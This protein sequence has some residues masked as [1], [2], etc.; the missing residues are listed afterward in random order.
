M[1]RKENNNIFFN[2]SIAKISIILLL[3]STTINSISTITRIPR[4]TIARFKTTSYSSSVDSNSI[5]SVDNRS[6]YISSTISDFVDSE[7][8][9]SFTSDPLQITMTSKSSNTQSSSTNPIDSNS[10]SDS[11]DTTDYSTVLPTRWRPRNR[12]GGASAATKQL[13]ISTSLLA[14][15]VILISA[16]LVLF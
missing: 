15:I 3:H 9:D 7:I 14:F 12:F 6:E 16:I 2:V 5:D 4:T 8:T 11:I 10:G 13:N 1:K